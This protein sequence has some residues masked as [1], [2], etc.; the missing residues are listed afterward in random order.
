MRRGFRVQGG[1]DGLF[2]IHMWYSVRNFQRHNGLPVTGVIDEA[3]A[4]KLGLFS[5]GWVNQ[6]TG[7]AGTKARA[8]QQALVRF[9]LNLPGG[10]TGTYS[11][12]TANSVRTFQRITGLPVT[13][14]VDATTARALGVLVAPVRSTVWSNLAYRATGS[15]VV[16]AQRALMA[17]GFNVPGGANGVFSDYMWYYVRAFQRHHGL[18]RHRRDRRAHSPCAGHLRHVPGSLEPP[19]CR[20]H[21][22]RRDRMPNKRSSPPDS[23]SATGQTA[24]SAPDTYFAVLEYQRG[25]RLARYRDDRP[26]H[27]PVARACWMAAGLVRRRRGS[28]FEKEWAERASPPPNKR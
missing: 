18:A 17:A 13:G 2:S 15:R 25:P 26:V 23:T 16:S 6:R 24:C 20:Y 14:I 10:I 9:G 8:V 5:D 27:G 11:I 7:M 28:T 1:A 12:G 4:Q 22:Q 3:T 19:R 21:R